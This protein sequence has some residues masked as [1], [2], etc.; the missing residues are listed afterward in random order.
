MILYDLGRA[1]DKRVIDKAVRITDATTLAQ[2]VRRLKV[3]GALKK[4]VK[5]ASLRQDER[6]WP[7]RLNIVRRRDDEVLVEL[8]RYDG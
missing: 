6:Y 4:S 5:L 8:D 7:S 3:I 1:Y 2:I